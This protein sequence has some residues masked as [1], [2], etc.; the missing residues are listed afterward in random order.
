MLNKIKAALVAAT[1]IAAF[2]STGAQAQAATQTA[3]ARVTI[4]TAVQLAQNDVLDFGVVASGATA[5]TVTLPIGSNTRTCS[6]S[7][8]CVGTALRGRFTVTGASN[9]Y[10]VAI[11][12]PTSATLT[13]GTNT[14]AVALTPSITGFTSTGAAQSFFVG[15]TLTV[16]ASQAAGLYTG[17]Y[18]VSANYQ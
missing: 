16:G 7:V 9:G 2:A 4:L 6:A 18:T 14:M 1:A 15:G 12:V 5:G 10:S 11:T 13:S 8:T 3:D 17:T